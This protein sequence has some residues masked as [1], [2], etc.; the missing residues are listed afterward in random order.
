MKP[1]SEGFFKT[2]EMNNFFRISALLLFPLLLWQCDGAQQSSNVPD[3]KVPEEE[4][5]AMEITYETKLVEMQSGPCGGGT[6]CASVY[7][8]APILNGTTQPAQQHIQQQ[9]MQEMTRPFMEEEVFSSMDEAAKAFVDA[10]RLTQ[11]QNEGYEK[12]WSL[13][14]SAEVY[15]NTDTLFGVKF[16]GS[17]DMGG[18]HPIGTIRYL[19]FKPATGE[20]LQAEQLAN[21]AKLQEWKAAAEAQFRQE[22]SLSATE[23][24]EAAGYW[25]K[26]DQFYLPRNFQLQEDSIIFYFNPYEVAPYAEGVVEIA[27]ER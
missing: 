18:A 6:P 11:K 15:A 16:S 22:R 12:S 23:S 2:V 20:L 26:N 14:R 5:A 10:Y 9:I 8:T 24:L 19:N 4:S 27:V 3:G 25:F 7:L 13:T 17:L 21:E 1:S